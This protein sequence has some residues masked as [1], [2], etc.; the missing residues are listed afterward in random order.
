MSTTLFQPPAQKLEV[1]PLR[2]PE[3]DFRSLLRR[4]GPSLALWR[5]AEIAAL[6]R[7]C[8]ERPILDL[9]CGDGIVTS[10]VLN[11]VDIG[12]D[13]DPHAL[14]KASHTGIYDR[15]MALAVERAPLPE[16]GVGTVLSNS[17]LEHIAQIDG[18]LAAVARVLEPGGRFVFTVP[19][20]AF[21][22]WLALP[23]A[24]YSQRRNRQLAHLNLWTV[25]EWAEHLG[26]AGLDLEEV[27]PYLRRRWVAIWDF[28]E[29][30]QSVW[31]GRRRVF[32][33]FWKRLPSRW[34][35][36]LARCAASIDLASSNP[37]GGRLMIGYKH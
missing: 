17:V 21:A 26:R 8:F 13:P 23:S 32:G 14:A 24:R 28:L 20:D 1:T 25:Q 29:L 37:G 10:Y 2:L 31:I 12:L 4:L 5:G 7:Q 33:L 35:D 34:L 18:V 11:H 16:H 19:T 3:R 9:G 27:H 22:R 30:L 36:W 6:R 15:L